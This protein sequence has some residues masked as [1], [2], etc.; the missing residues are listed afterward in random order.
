MATKSPILTGR[1]NDP[2]VRNCCLDQAEVC[3][4]CGRKLAEI[5]EW[6][7]ADAARREAI[8]SAASTRL[9]ARGRMSAGGITRHNQA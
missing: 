6:H 9:D 8:L 1:D 3:L 7:G 5:I 4:G 2:C